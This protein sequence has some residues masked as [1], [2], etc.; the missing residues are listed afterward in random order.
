MSAIGATRSGSGVI[1]T[2]RVCFFSALLAVLLT[3]GVSSASG[4]IYQY[5]DYPITPIRFS[6]GKT[7][8]TIN[9]SVERGASATYTFVA[10]EGQHADIQLTTEEDN[11]S[12]IFYMPGAT[13]SKDDGGYDVSGP[14]LPNAGRH[15]RATHWTGRLPVSGKYTLTIQPSRGGATYHLTVTIK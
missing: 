11:A 8:A 1:S 10:R 13:V 5:G 12:F 14:T 3:G 7:T 6:S 9:D 4:Q 2:K 15:G